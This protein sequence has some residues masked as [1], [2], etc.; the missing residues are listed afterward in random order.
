MSKQ[1]I[2]RPEART[3]TVES[4]VGSVLRGQVRIP[5]FQRP[6]RWEAVQVVALFDSIYKGYPIGSLLLQKK[7]ANAD[8]VIL[9]PLHIIAPAVHDALWI[10]DGQQR[11]TSLA[12]GLAR[13]A[14]VPTTPDDPFVVYFD[15]K[16]HTFQS[17]QRSGVVPSTWVPVAQLLDASGLMEWIFTWQHNQ[18]SELR[19]AVFETGRRLR[20]YQVPLYTIQTEEESVLRDIFYRTNTFGKEMTWEDVHKALFSRPGEYPSTLSELSEELAA[21]QMGQPTEQQLLISLLAFEGLD[22]TRNLA[23]HARRGG[24]EELDKLQTSVRDS[25]PTFG[26]VLDFLRNDAEIPHLHLLARIPPFAV[27]TRYFRLFPSPSSRSIQL[28]VRWT[29]R[30]LTGSGLYKERTLLRH[31]AISINTGNDEYQA[32]QLLRL[33]P[34]KLPEQLLYQLPSRFDARATDTRLA[35]CAMYQQQPIGEDGQL[36]VLNKLELLQKSSKKGWPTIVSAKNLTSVNM[37]LAFGPANRILLP[38]NKLLLPR[39]MA[40]EWEQDADFLNS[41]SITPE[42]LSALQKQ[43]LTTFLRLRGEEIERLVRL[44]SGRLAAWGQPDRIS[45]SQLVA[46]TIDT[47]FTDAII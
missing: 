18:D 19:T 1:L 25:L 4:L 11:L 29:W 35:L 12:A 31:G 6:L 5:S 14:P 3:A 44:Q 36:I 28:L 24:D 40:A 42:A 10:I 32:Q 47:D 22:P 26:R 7:P 23:A 38:D 27:L 34:D 39:L 20:E 16:T 2:I 37:P 9:G 13:P 8:E 17:P 21:K 46:Q 43:D 33:V 30:A 15:A 45:I 41:H